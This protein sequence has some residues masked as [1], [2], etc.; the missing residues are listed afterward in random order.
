MRQPRESAAG[1]AG[2]CRFDRGVERKE[3]CLF[4]NLRDQ[5]DDIVD[6]PG[7]ERKLRDAL[8]GLLRLADGGT[9]DPVG[10]LWTCRPILSTDEV[11]SSV[12]AATAWIFSVTVREDETAAELDSDIVRSEVLVIVDAEASSSVE[13][14]A[15]EPTSSPII[16]SK[17]PVAV[18]IR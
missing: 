13:A 4:G 11:I 15:S 3:I 17:L 14:D 6:A 12:A 1:L 18:L 9:G 7:S 5:L 16:A 10:F 8:V 2:T